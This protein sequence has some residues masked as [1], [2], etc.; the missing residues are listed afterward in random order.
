MPVILI[1]TTKQNVWL[2]QPLLAAELYTVEYHPVEHQ[3]DMEVKE[4]VVNV[5]FLPVV[6]DTIRVPVEQAKSTST[7]IST[8][9]SKE[10]AVF[11]PRPNTQSAEFNFEA[12]VKCLPFQLNLGDEAKLT[13]VQQ[14]QFIDLIYDH[15]E[16]FSLHDEDLRFCD[17]I[18]HT[19][20]MTMD[21]P[22]YLVHC[23]IPP[24]LQGEVHKC[25]NTWLWQ[26][27]IRPSQ[28]PY[29]SQMVIVQKKTGEI[30][31][32]MDYRKLNSIMVRDA[33][34]SPRIDEALQA[35][36]SSNW[37]LSFGLAQ[38]YL[39]LAMEESNI[40]KTVFRAGSTG[41]YVFTHMPFRLS[42]AGSS[43][44]HLMEQ[45]LGDQQFVTLLLYLDDI[46]I[47]VPTID[48]MLGWIHLVFDRLKKFNLKIKPKK[49]QFFSTSVLF[50]GHVL[51]P[52]GIS[53]NPDK[54]DKV[55]TWPLPKNI[56]E[57]QSF[58]GL[59]SYYRHF[60]PHFAKKA[61][62]LHELVGPAA[63]KPK[64]RTKA[65]NKETQAAETIPTEVEPKIFEWTI[66]HQEAFDALKEALCTAPVLGYPD[67]NREFIL[68]TDAS[69]KGLGTVLSQQH[70]DG[71]IHVIAYASQSLCPSERSMCN[72]SSAKLELLVLKWAVTEKFWDYLLG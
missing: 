50:L 39:Q 33:F 44:C 13:C 41:L 65:R 63:S 35:V 31:L 58:L 56:K 8:P 59:A 26:G 32:C 52:V 27:I 10:N 7:D 5:S 21:K 30:H 66:E 22:V 18:K 23:T 29:A 9:N 17:W 47:F 4:D 53:A 45:C 60:I 54:V 42:N 62:C 40:N 34:P 71:S 64:K 61:W 11:G 37:F 20:P 38:G 67:F 12:E 1:N 25:L 36:H 68:E 3:V 14:S 15:P 16:V 28:S 49:C 6:P 43:F 72:Y 19:I 55:K 51:S 48:G 70:K 46:C 57:V 69:L 24:Q 2:Q